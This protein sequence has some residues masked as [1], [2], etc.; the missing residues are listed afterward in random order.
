MIK[1]PLDHEVIY[2]ATEALRPTGIMLPWP[3]NTESLVRIFEEAYNCKI[4]MDQFGLIGNA[5]FEDEKYAT[6]LLLKYGS[7]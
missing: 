3:A 5:I 1:I 2:A 6:A 4:E 7:K